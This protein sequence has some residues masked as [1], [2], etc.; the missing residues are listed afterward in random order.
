MS[1]PKGQTIL[2]PGDLAY[3]DNH[4]N[5]DQRKWDTWGRFMEPCAA[6]QPIIY[7]AGNHEIDFVPN[8][9][10]FTYFKS[11]FVWFS[12]GLITF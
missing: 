9:V 12:F 4:P 6:Y 10:R 2:F 11:N 5:H 7:A 8:I 3:Q 1:N